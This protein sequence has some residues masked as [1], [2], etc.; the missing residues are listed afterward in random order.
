MPTILLTGKFL[1]QWS[2]DSGM[3]NH[4]GVGIWHLFCISYYIRNKNGEKTNNNWNK[5]GSILNLST[6]ND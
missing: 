5:W 4:V 2:S 6:D 3:C 1:T